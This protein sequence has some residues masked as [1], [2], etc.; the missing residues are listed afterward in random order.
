MAPAATG[1]KRSQRKMSAATGRTDRNGAATSN[2]VAP[3]PI[4][5]AIRARARARHGVSTSGKAALARPRLEN[6]VPSCRPKPQEAL[7]AG[8]HSAARGRYGAFQTE[9]AGPG[10]RQ[11]IARL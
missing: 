2:T 6:A 10:G 5:R 7:V 3:K 8:A 11:Q 4:F 1:S 9:M